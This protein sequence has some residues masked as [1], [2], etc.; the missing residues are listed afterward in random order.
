MFQNG[1]AQFKNLA[2]NVK[3]LKITR[4]IFNLIYWAEIEISLRY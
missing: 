2:A 3:I 1:Q 4:I